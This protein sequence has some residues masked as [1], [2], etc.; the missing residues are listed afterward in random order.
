MVLE[1]ELEALRDKN[2]TL[3]NEISK[4][5]NTVGGLKVIF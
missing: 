4:M 1:L 3:S 5:T 2:G